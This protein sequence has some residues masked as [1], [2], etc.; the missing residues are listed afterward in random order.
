MKIIFEIYV[1]SVK[2]S[3]VRPTGSFGYKLEIVKHPGGG[4]EQKFYD[5]NF[6]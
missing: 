6:F 1:D 5:K 3:L 4:S 2:G